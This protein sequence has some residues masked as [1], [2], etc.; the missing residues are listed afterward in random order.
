MAERGFEFQGRP[1]S[2]S[3]EDCCGSGCTPCVLDIYEQELRLWKLSLNQIKPCTPIRFALSTDSYLN[4]VISAMESITHDV[5][6]YTIS[7]LDKDLICNLFP[8]SHI[9]LQASSK[10]N[11]H[12]ITR[13]YTPISSLTSVGS[14]D[15]IIKVYCDGRMSALV[16]EWSIGS[17]V[18]IR[19]PFGSFDI[20]Q[21]QYKYMSMLAC[22][23]GIAPMYQVMRQMLEN[24][25][26]E[27]RIILLYS[28]STA[29]DILL[30]QQ[31]DNFA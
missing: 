17:V 23:T 10:D 30:K 25:S 29:K 15:L 16:R 14:L 28:V 18:R 8:G 5:I 6:L 7:F 22:G 4:C 21:N 11:T 2:P 9:I 24:E 31:L 1:I 3:P 27:T 26:E 20:K 12:T 13:Q 19:G